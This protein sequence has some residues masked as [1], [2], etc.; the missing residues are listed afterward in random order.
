MFIDDEDVDCTCTL[1]SEKH[2]CFER[3]LWREDV[4]LFNLLRLLRIW[5][6][7]V[8]IGFVLHKHVTL[9]QLTYI[10]AK[11]NSLCNASDTLYTKLKLVF[12]H[13]RWIITVIVVVGLLLSISVDTRHTPMCMS[14]AA[15]L[16]QSLNYFNRT[17]SSSVIQT[18]LTDVFKAKLSDDLQVLLCVVFGILI[19]C[20]L[21]SLQ[22]FW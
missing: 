1:W 7:P 6:E 3:K 18:S 16:K 12:L 19:S 11:V 9:M 10:L 8:V 4:I 20:T 14:G 17:E 22:S 5:S 13:E 15:V 2:R 21:V